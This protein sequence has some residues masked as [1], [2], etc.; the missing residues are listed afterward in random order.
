MG[1]QSLKSVK[2]KVLL[3]VWVSHTRAFFFNRVFLRVALKDKNYEPPYLPTT[4]ASRSNVSYPQIQ[5]C[6]SPPTITTTQVICQ[7]L[8]AMISLISNHP[9]LARRTF[10]QKSQEQE[11]QG[12]F[13]KTYRG[14]YVPHFG[15]QGPL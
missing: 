8:V 7:V 10:M 15:P 12:H 11:S 5:N 2:F 3:T 4:I 14:L 13:Y 9:L 6:C 1:Q